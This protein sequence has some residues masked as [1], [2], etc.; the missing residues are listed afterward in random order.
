MASASWTDGLASAQAATKEGKF[1]D[2][3]QFLNSCMQDYAKVLGDESDKVL[4]LPAAFV[5]EVEPKISQEQKETL[6]QMYV[7]RGDIL[8]GLGANKRAAVDY[9]CAQALGNPDAALKEKLSK[10]QAAVKGADP[11]SKI[12][13]TVLTGFLGDPMNP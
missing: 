4:K 7:L 1:F 10:V 12:P 6:R 3:V 5:E 13:V 2:A 11:D 9:G 8:V